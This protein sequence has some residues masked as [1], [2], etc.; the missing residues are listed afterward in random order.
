MDSST[1]STTVPTPSV[2]GVWGHFWGHKT[3]YCGCVGATPD[4]SSTREWGVA[5]P[6]SRPHQGVMSPLR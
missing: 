3:A 1:P 6:S 2:S 4:D 5:C